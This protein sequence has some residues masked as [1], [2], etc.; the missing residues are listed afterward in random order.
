M[1]IIRAVAFVGRNNQERIVELLGRDHDV[2][3]GQVPG[4]CA[5][6]LKDFHVT[7][8]L[9]DDDDNPTYFRKLEKTIADDCK[10]GEHVAEYIFRA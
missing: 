10:N 5:K 4:R 6:C 3:S 2:F 8:A 7:F 1:P 9:K